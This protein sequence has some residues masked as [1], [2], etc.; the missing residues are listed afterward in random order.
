MFVKEELINKIRD[1][2]DLNMYEA[3]AWLA[4]LSKGIASAGEVAEISGI[5]RS[6]T[7]DVLENLEKKGFA[8]VKLGK[9]VRYIGVKPEVIIEKLKNNVQKEAREKI[10]YISRIKETEE[11]E[12]LK[13]LYEQNENFH[14]EASASILRGKLNI[15]N[16]LRDFLESATKEVLIC[17]SLLDIYPRLSSFKTIV[18]TLKKRGI[19]IKIAM[20]GEED[21]IKEVS[22]KIGIKIKKIDINAKFFIVDKKE[23]LFYISPYEE[24]EQIALWLNSP[25]FIQ[26]IAFL[27]DK[28]IKS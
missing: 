16:Q 26:S 10:E 25:F 13:A 11:F 22:E 5:P 9:P 2:F 1:I 27:F 7:Y 23:A 12:K 19:K 6:R 3:K 15:S 14:K 8:L 20:S 24:R 21:K 18:D 4:L 17:T 28:V